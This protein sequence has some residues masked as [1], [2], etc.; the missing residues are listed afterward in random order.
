MDESERMKNESRCQVTWRR[1]M[2]ESERM[3]NES[4]FLEAK[5]ACAKTCAALAEAAEASRTFN[6]HV[7]WL[8]EKPPKDTGPVIRSLSEDVCDLTRVAERAAIEM[9]TVL[10]KYRCRNLLE[11]EKDKK[12][13]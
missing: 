6:C 1:K 13:G 4:F 7:N 8:D 5:R 2:D 3:K 10:G 9:L 12:D 11:E